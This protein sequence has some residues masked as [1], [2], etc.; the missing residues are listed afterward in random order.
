MPATAKK[1]THRFETATKQLLHLVTHALYSNK[2]VFLRELISNA[3][4]ACDKLRF[5]ALDNSKVYENDPELKIQIEFDKKARTVTVRDNGIGMNRDDV[6]SHLGTI[7]KSGTREF[8]SGLTGDQNKDSKLI[9]QFGVGFYSAFIVADKVTV[10][11]RRAGEAAGKGVRWISEGAGEYDI[12]AIEKKDR[13]TE[14]ILHLK[15]EEKD[16]LE[17]WQLRQII[18]KYSD[19]IDLPIYM[20]KTPEPEPAAEEKEKEKDKDKDKAKTKKS[21]KEKAAPEWEKVNRAKALWTLAKKDIKAEDYKEFYKH[22]SHDFEDPLTWALNK[23]EG[24]QEYTSLL[25]VPSRAPFDLWNREK[26]NGGLKLYVRRVF[27]MDEAEQFLPTYL[28]FVKGVIDS[29]DLPLNVSR[30]ILQNNKVVSAIKSG[31]TKRVLSM[32]EKVAKNDKENYQKFWEAMGKVLKEGPAEDYNNKER[33]GKLLRFASTHNDTNVQNVS[34]A[35]YIERMKPEQKKIYYVTADN[36]ASA[37][38][39]P[40]LEVFR[41]K[42]IEVLLLSDNVDEWLTSHLTEFDGKPLQ[43]VSK[44]D[45]D[46]GDLADKEEKEQQDKEK[47]EF[48]KINEQIKKILGDK[49]EDVRVTHRLTDSPAC[50]VVKDHEM[51][52]HLQRIMQSAGQPM[53]AGKPILELNP[54]HAIIQRLKAEVDEE[55]FEEWS[56]ILFDQALLAEGGK[57]ENPAE[58]VQRLNKM[59]LALSA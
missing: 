21:K 57:L 46:L 56:N 44:G 7:A 18:T 30:E 29:H 28:R 58:F 51:S 45:L 42:E 4:D 59:L 2:E 5:M 9:G 34:F 41:K 37:K 39:S 14:I 10:N 38:N 11:T 19:Y 3:A 20:Q 1:E 31:I 25:Y 47:D 50:L 36:F 27:I 32:L 22:V 15:K 26:M 23:V 13:G 17:Q 40:H 54:H 35:D 52:A 48:T 8:L 16:F 33:I 6:I 43:S 49:V 12:E 55:R 24:K 53:M